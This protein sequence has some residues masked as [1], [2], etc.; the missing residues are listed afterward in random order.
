MKVWCPAAT[1]LAMRR[2]CSA[3]QVRNVYIFFSFW[4]LFVKLH[5]YPPQLLNEPL[6]RGVKMYKKWEEKEKGLGL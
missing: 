6:E 2:A 5:S 3:T 1:A 4:S